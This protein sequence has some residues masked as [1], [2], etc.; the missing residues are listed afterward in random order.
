VVAVVAAAAAA[1][2]MVA[3]VVLK[4]M[5]T[6]MMYYWMRIGIVNRATLACRDWSAFT[7]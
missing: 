3:M 7:L 1:R 2:I 4:R 5:P 6:D